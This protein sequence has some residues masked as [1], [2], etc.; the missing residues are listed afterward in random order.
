MA[1]AGDEGAAQPGGPS[2]FG[3]RGGRGNA[4]GQS[5]SGFQPLL[6]WGPQVGVFARRAMY[7]EKA[8]VDWKNDL[9]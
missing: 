1:F 8:A 9:A 7:V 3:G 2:G 4:R 6:A 5:G